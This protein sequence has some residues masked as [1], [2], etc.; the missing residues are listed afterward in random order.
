MRLLLA[1]AKAAMSNRVLPAGTGL[2]H[3]SPATVD[4]ES[5]YEKNQ[6][7]AFMVQE[8]EVQSA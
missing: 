5:C 8:F 4:L 3:L 1:A 2:P 6:N 7:A